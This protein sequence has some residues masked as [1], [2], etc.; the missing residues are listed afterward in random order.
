[1]TSEEMLEIVEVAIAAYPKNYVDDLN[2]L[3]KSWFAVMGKYNKELVFHAVYL[4][5][6]RCKNFPSIAEVVEEIRF[7]QL[8]NREKELKVLEA[9][10]I[11]QEL[12]EINKN[13]L[14]LL[15]Q[16]KYSE[17]K[18]IPEVKE[19]LIRDGK[20]LKSF[21]LDY[22]GDITVEFIKNNY[23]D[24]NYFKNCEEVCLK[25]TSSEN[26]PFQGYRMTA[27]IHPKGYVDLTL[28]LCN[29]GEKQ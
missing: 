9:P 13:L 3:T 8:E 11:S 26:C 1:M 25:C 28:I 2:R 20:A 16:G 23:N 10:S 19:V 6:Q 27:E 12:R 15:A 29:K 7:V 5:L 21:C 4:C 17:A 14:K 18:Q 24:L 22:W